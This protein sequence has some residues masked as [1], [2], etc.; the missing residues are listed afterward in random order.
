ME[1]VKLSLDYSAAVSAN[2]VLLT[3]IAQKRDAGAPLRKRVE[4]ARRS[5]AAL[6]EES[7]LLRDF[8][9]KHAQLAA[10][11]TDT[12]VTHGAPVGVVDDTLSIVNQ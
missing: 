5:I 7:A 1:G 10:S 2:K 3:D 12:P 9:I 11:A 6:Q 4:T 8:Q